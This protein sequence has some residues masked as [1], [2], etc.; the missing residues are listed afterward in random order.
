MTRLR[1]RL[2]L[3]SA[4][5]WLVRWYRR[6]PGHRWAYVIVGDSRYDSAWYRQCVVCD[7]WEQRRSVGVGSPGEWVRV[8][9]G[10]GAYA[11]AEHVRGPGT[12]A[13][14]RPRA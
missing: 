2:L 11:P 4:A 3:L 14:V 6:Q 5:L 10:K 13:F 7:R 1:G 12:Y 8:P 9:V